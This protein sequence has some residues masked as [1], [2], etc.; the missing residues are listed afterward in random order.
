MKLN[1]QNVILKYPI[2]TI[3]VIYLLTN[4]FLFTNAGFFWDDWCM[5]SDMALNS[6]LTGVG[7]SY[8]YPVHSFLLNL[9]ENSMTIRYLV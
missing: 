1:N 3:V 9:I 5:T 7:S 4:F 2:A 6:I 8:L